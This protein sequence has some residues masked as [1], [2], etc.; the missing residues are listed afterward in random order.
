MNLI[1]LKYVRL[2][3]S[4]LYFLRY[5]HQ[6]CNKVSCYN[7]PP[8]RSAISKTKF[9]ALTIFRQ[10]L[11][12]LNLIIRQSLKTADVYNIEQ[13]NFKSVFHYSICIWCVVCFWILSGPIWKCVYRGRH[14]NYRALAGRQY[15]ASH[16]H[17]VIASGALWRR[18]HL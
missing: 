14:W 16:G 15:N 7:D 12:N 13:V 1:I 6:I 4:L 2:L 18:A 10:H 8:A 5:T 17:P 9:L 11:M 3:F